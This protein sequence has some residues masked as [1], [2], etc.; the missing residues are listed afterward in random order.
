[1][2]NPAPAS[3]VVAVVTLLVTGTGLWTIRWWLHRRRR[4]SADPSPL[5]APLAEPRQQQQQQQQVQLQEVLNLAT[6]ANNNKNNK[7]HLQL[8]RLGLPMNMPSKTKSC[9]S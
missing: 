7:I 8:S 9:R 6:D 1:M 5:E 4:T 3:S 2:P